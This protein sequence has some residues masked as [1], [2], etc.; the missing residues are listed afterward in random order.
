MT[1]R[2][3]L[4]R[5]DSKELTEW[6]AF[7]ALEPW[8]A[9]VEDWRAGMV[10]ATVANA[11]RDEKKRRKPYTPRD[12]MPQRIKPETEVESKTQ[13]PAEQAKTLGLWGRVWEEKF[14]EG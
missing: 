9:E 4:N 8:G 10:A 11:N 7:F 14:G 5:V 13:T 3:L 12:F 2:E 1:V 6:A